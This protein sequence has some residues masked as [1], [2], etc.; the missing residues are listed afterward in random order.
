MSLLIVQEGT[1]AIHREKPRCRG[2]GAVVTQKEVRILVRAAHTAVDTAFPKS[3]NGA[4]WASPD[5]AHTPQSTAGHEVLGIIPINSFPLL[6]VD[7]RFERKYTN[8]WF[9]RNIKLPF[10]VPNQYH[11]GYTSSSRE[12]IGIRLERYDMIC[13]FHARSPPKHDDNREEKTKTEQDQ[14]PVG[15][16]TAGLIRRSIKQA[17]LNRCQPLAHFGRRLDGCLS[18]RAI[19]IDEPRPLDREVKRGKANNQAQRRGRDT[20]APP[21]HE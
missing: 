14:R 12:A 4:R 10:C 2:T 15:T 17:S 16:A 1:H 18:H 11:N 20:P 21:S 7:G 5:Q 6:H 8:L 3:R 9:S 13:S 19:A